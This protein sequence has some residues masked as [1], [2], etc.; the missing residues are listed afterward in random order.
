MFN[1]VV[2]SRSPRPSLWPPFNWVLDRV[3]AV[4]H[5]NAN[6]TSSYKTS[7]WS[8]AFSIPGKNG[9]QS[10][11]IYTL[12][13]GC[14]CNLETNVGA[15]DNYTTGHRAEHNKPRAESE[16][17]PAFAGLLHSGDSAV[18]QVRCLPPPLLPSVAWPAADVVTC[19]PAC[20]HA[21]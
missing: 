11:I 12:V 1:R 2:S 3:W 20:Q 21:T 13:R 10:H 14:F 6:V 17:W 15:H 9:G 8:R 18:P 16:P 5:R 19:L 7:R 4:W